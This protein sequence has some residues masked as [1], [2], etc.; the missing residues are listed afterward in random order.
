MMTRIRW[1]LPI[2]IVAAALIVGS[3]DPTA[4]SAVAPVTAP[5]VEL[6]DDVRLLSCSPLPADSVTQVIGPAGGVLV[7]GPHRFIVP[8]GALDSAVAITAT[9][10]PE[11]VDRVHFAPEGLQ[12]A[13]PARLRMSYAHCGPV[14]WLVPRFIVHV[15]EDL[16]IL[17]VLPSLND[18]LRQRVSARIE[19]FSD[20][21]VAW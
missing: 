19:H 21:A 9:I 3:C 17:D 11:A 5:P 20:Y 15:D 13:R 1:L 14:S 12:F 10:T 16:S 7:V 4:P 18:V 6:L 2:T 8:E